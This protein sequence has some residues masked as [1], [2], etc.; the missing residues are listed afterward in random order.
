MD[1]KE[2]VSILDQYLFGWA[3]K[4]IEQASIHGEAKL[5]GF[6]LGACFID[7]M[8]GFYAGIDKERSKHKLSG[9]S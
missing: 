1:K 8:A 6:I 9:S 2:L 3:Y 7:A 4:Q 5:A